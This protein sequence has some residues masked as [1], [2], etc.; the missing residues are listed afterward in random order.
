MIRGSC[1]LFQNYNLQRITPFSCFKT[2]SVL[3]IIDVLPLLH[4]NY[5]MEEVHMKQECLTFPFKIFISVL[6][7]YVFIVPSNIL[8]FCN[9]SFLSSHTSLAPN[10]KGFEIQPC[11]ICTRIGSLF[12]FLGRSFF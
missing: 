2:L 11:P 9:F 1:C 4:L 7:E 12:S 8:F 5:E 10:P 3:F 6:I